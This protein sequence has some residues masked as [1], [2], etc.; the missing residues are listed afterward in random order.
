[1]KRHFIVAM[2]FILVTALFIST[3]HPKVAAAATFAD[4]EYNVPF[5]VLKDNSNEVSATADY[6]VSPAKVQ[7]TNDKATV[8]VTLKNSSWWQYFKVQNGGTYSDVQVVSESGDQRVVRFT[9]SDLTRLVNGKIHIIV[10]GIPGFEYD[11]KYDIRF[12][13]NTS[14]IP[15]PPVEKPVST[16]PAK[17]TK[18]ETPKK[19]EAKPVQ[20][21][22]QKTAE[23]PAGQKAETTKKTEEEKLVVTKSEADKAQKSEEKSDEKTDEKSE[24]K[25]NEVAEEKSETDESDVTKE[26]EQEASEDAVEEQEVEIVEEAAIEEVKEETEDSSSPSV[27]LAILALIAAVI[28]GFVFATQ[29]KRAR[30]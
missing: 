14:S 30:K 7:L 9:V 15:A 13:F 17:E 23:K 12:S 2:T 5:T 24:E 8:T 28:A 20:K 1:M 21:P 10:T 25:S 22:A 11:N 3:I 27:I 6:M 4:G 26:D 18:P 29:K 19:E 16:P